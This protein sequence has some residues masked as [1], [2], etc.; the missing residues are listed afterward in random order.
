MVTRLFT[1]TLS[2]WIIANMPGAMPGFTI[3]RAAKAI[4]LPCTVMK[5]P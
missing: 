4:T 1:R 5:R 3:G 2:D